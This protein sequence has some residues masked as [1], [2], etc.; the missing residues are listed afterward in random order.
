VNV[1][2]NGKLN[3]VLRFFRAILS[4]I[5]IVVQILNMALTGS[6]TEKRVQDDGYSASLPVYERDFYRA[7][8]LSDGYYE[9]YWIEPLHILT[10]TPLDGVEANWC[11]GGLLSLTYKLAKIDDSYIEKCA[12]VV[13]GLRYYRRKVGR[14]FDGYSYFRSIFKETTVTGVAYDD[15]MWL[16]RDLIGLYELTGET[17]YLDLA[18]EI[19]DYL[20]RSA[21]VDLDPQMFIDFGYEAERGMPLGGFFWDDHHDAIHAC[22][23]GPAVQLLA[24]LYRLTGNEIYLEHAVKSFNFL[25]FLVRWDG[26][27]HD[28]MRFLKD[29][30][31]NIIGIKGPAGP[32]FSYNSGAPITGAIELYKVTGEEEYLSIARYW[33]ASAHAYFAMDSHVEGIKRY[34]TINIWFNA[35]LLNGFLALEPYS[36]E[37]CAVYINSMQAS[38]DYAYD[39]FLTPS[40]PFFGPFLPDDWVGGWGHQD[41]KDMWVLNAG[42][43]AEIYATLA[44]YNMP[45]TD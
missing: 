16:A 7:K 35:I 25:R 43:Q 34:P 11:Y 33:A 8:I 6:L 38:I 30:F 4:C 24:A 12:T 18:I 13:E 22:S 41:P 19:A 15:N 32:P 2:V 17:K 28:Q 45:K 3:A 20:I 5:L 23:N 9:S 39:N 36:P 21:F 29:G 14:N 40:R 27:L 42:A 37:D 44:Y 10:S 31:N 1:I 26:V